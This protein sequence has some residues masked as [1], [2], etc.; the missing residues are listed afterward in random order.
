MHVL[1]KISQFITAMST[2]LGKAAS[3]FLIGFMCVLSYEVIARYGFNS[4]TIWAHELA[5]YLLAFYL[6]LTGPW[7]LSRGDHVNVDIVYARYSGRK[8]TIADMVSNLI[9]I[10]F[11]VVVFLIGM[12]YA[13]YAYS[14]GQTS[15]T[16]WG[17]PVWPVKFCI[18]LSAVLFILQAIANIC[19]A[20]V[21]LTRTNE[22]GAS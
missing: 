13:M 2:F 8:K 19:G 22:V 6:A 15:H 14:I 3:F 11:F 7:L 1:Q 20:I 18:P 12:R 21:K 10:F 9:V 16:V 5:G 4:P 17:P